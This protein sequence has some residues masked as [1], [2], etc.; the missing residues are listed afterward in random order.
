MVLYG[1]F[2]N[3]TFFMDNQAVLYIARLAA[4]NTFLH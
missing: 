1:T 3:F 2:T 4:L